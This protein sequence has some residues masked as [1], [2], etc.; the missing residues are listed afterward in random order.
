[1]FV[2]LG[3]YSEAGFRSPGPAGLLK[4]CRVI[5]I[6][7]IIKSV[8]SLCVS[9]WTMGPRPLHTTSVMRFKCC[10]V[11][12]LPGPELL[13]GRGEEVRHRRGSDRRPQLSTVDER[14]HSR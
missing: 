2:L 6:V 8:R 12:F 5:I 9:E 1:M 10:A 7:V 14:D 4:L 11:A 3:P 13:H